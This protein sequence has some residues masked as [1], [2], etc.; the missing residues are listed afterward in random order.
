M[1]EIALCGINLQFLY[2][3]S[4]N[5][6]CIVLPDIAMGLDCSARAVGHIPAKIVDFCSQAW[7][8]GN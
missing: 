6:E 4:G 3:A 1:G 5:H 7:A 2:Q 8:A